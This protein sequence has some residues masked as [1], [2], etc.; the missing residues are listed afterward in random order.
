[1]EAINACAHQVVWGEVLAGR[2]VLKRAGVT[3]ELRRLQGG[4]TQESR[5]KGGMQG[6]VTQ[7]SCHIQGG[8]TQESRRCKS[9]F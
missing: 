1:M 5:G 7:E 2:R 9:V 6:G 3:Q 4:V 8:V